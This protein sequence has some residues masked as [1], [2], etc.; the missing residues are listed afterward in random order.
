MSK[1][2]VLIRRHKSRRSTEASRWHTPQ[3]DRLLASPPT[4]KTLVRRDDRE[5][6]WRT[7]ASYMES[8]C[9]P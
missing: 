1:S 3:G 4:H 5:A 9:I 7:P 6:A 8:G 2:I